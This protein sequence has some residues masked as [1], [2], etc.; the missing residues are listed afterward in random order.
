MSKTCLNGVVI[1]WH[2]QLPMKWHCAHHNFVVFYFSQGK[3]TNK[4]V[5]KLKVFFVFFST[6]IYSFFCI[7]YHT[8]KER[9]DERARLY[10]IISFISWFFH[11]C[12]RN[13][14]Y[15]GI[16]QKEFE[17]FVFEDADRVVDLQETNTV[18][19]IDD[20]RFY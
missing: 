3:D 10:S 9:F 11:Y 16:K 7:K 20:L 6:I 19:I 15:L 12:K 17:K 8:Y 13:L 14:F 4:F 2:F 1:K 18:P 5:C